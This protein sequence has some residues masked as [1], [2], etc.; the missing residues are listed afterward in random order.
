MEDIIWKRLEKLDS[1]DLN[2]IH[3][4]SLDVEVKYQDIE[5]LYKNYLSKYYFETESNNNIFNDDEADKVSLK[6]SLF[7]PT[8]AIVIEEL[9]ESSIKRLDDDLLLFYIKDQDCALIL[10][11]SFYP[12]D[13]IE[14]VRLPHYCYYIKNLNTLKFFEKQFQDNESLCLMYCSI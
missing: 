4:Y 9:F 12:L 1:N 5:I 10:F 8:L 13:E 7:E 2:F 6:L 3:Y 14:E 11:K